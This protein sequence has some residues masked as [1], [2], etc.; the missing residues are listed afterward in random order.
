[1]KKEKELKTVKT[2]IMMYCHKKHKTKGKVLCN[3]CIEL[4]QFVE[5]KRN[6]CPFGDE[7]GFCAN[8]RIHCYKSNTIMRDRI[9]IVMK[10]S[11]PRLMFKH[12]IMS[13]SHMIE[14]IK[15]NKENRKI[16]NDR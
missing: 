12:P 7:K 5:V 13:I 16:K 2:M 11:G 3:E 10:Y 8:C 14:T 4:Y 15:K 9:R 6:R 1:M